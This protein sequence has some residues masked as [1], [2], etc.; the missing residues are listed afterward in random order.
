MLKNVT[1][2]PILGG[3]WNY[4]TGHG[5]AIIARMDSSHSEA[6]S[7]HSKAQKHL[8]SNSFD[9]WLSIDTKNSIL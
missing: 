6:V 5:G 9:L 2:N 4:V 8:S 1:F 7:R 3:L